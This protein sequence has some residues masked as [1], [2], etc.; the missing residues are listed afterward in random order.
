M[1]RTLARA[2]A[3]PPPE[4]H[5]RQPPEQTVAPAVSG[6]AA[7]DCIRRLLSTLTAPFATFARRLTM[8][9]F[10]A[11]CATNLALNSP[12]ALGAARHSSAAPFLLAVADS[13]FGSFV[14]SYLATYA[15][16]AIVLLLSAGRREVNEQ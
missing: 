7:P 12:T 16:G 9:L 1:A 15:A 4:E 3:L 5:Q 2:A 10:L 6:H 8:A 13:A 14:M 11:A